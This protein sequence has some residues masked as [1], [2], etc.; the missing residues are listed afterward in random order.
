M[1]AYP[2]I[3]VLGLGNPLRGDDGVGPRLVEELTRRGLPPGVTA[4]DGGTGGLD[5]LQVLQGWQRV[6]VVDAA[7]VGREPGQFVRFT[8]D[9]GRLAQATDRMSLHNAGLGEILA[10]ANALEQTLPHIVIFG[11]QPAEVDWRR[12]L[13]P[14]VEIMLPALA[15][16]VLEEIEGL[17]ENAR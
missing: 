2:S 17:E 7:D 1:S 8:P 13:S 12:G 4:L 9:Q 10:L 11:V 16:A 6:V 14:A 5:L 15:D 3:L